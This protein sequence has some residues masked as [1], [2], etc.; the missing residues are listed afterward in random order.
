MQEPMSKASAA[1]AFARAQ[2][3]AR[4]SALDASY[5][6]YANDALAQRACALPE[7]EAASTLLTYLSFGTEVDTHVIIE[8]A[9]RERKVVALPFCVPHT[10]V[11]RWFQITS[12]EGLATSP[13]GVEEPVPCTANEILPQASRR[14]LALVPALTFDRLGYRMGYGGGF[15]DTFLEGFRGI[16]VGLC[17]DALLRNDLAAEGSLEAHD[18]PVNVVLTETQ[19][20]RFPTD[21]GA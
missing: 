18:K 4:R 19:T 11:M 7:F 16:S 20:L 15:Y 9:W 6:A 12:F 2:S 8:Q 14:M 13:L 17:Y 3:K 21:G 5:R 10:R 1:K